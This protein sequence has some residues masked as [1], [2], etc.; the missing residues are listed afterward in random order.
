MPELVR[1]ADI[2]HQNGFDQVWVND[3]LTYRNLFVVLT[4]MAA[5]VPIKL[6][7]AI[8]V[9]YFR[10][11]VDLAGTVAAITELTDGREFSLGIA[12]GASPIAGNQVEAVKPLSM[13]RET[14]SSLRALLS[15]EVIMFKDFSTVGSDFH[16]NP[17]REFKL[18]FS[19]SAPVHFY[20]GGGGP[21]NLAIAGEIMDGVLIGGYYIPLAR[22]GR[23][24]GMLEPSRALAAKV[25]PNNPPFDTC[26]LNVSISEDRQ[27][28]LDF[29]KT[30]VSHIL[31]TLRVMGFSDDEIFSL[32]VEPKLIDQL[33][34]AFESGATISESKKLVPDE[35]VGSC[36]VAGTPDECREQILELMD[37]AHRLK[38][39]QV[40]FS[41]LGPNYEEA[42]ML[43]RQKVLNK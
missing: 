32:G 39:G 18:S 12:R 37:E 9:P 3:N 31:P 23:L 15:G 41:K 30:Y 29:A 36:F 7:T 27:S 34:D 5:R 28:A 38:F 11:P 17:D 1:L 33:E 2:G 19:P 8:M 10:N 14:V 13:I 26:E 6:G 21:K 22:S 42:I 20:S 25:Q 4:A 40:C 35:A 43:L 16:I 24:Q